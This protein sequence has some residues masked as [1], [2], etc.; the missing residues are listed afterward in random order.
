M[1]RTLLAVCGLSPQVITETLYA[2]LQDGRLP[3]SVHV[4]T[5]TEGKARCLSNLFGSGD[6]HFYKFLQDYELPEDAINFSP[7]PCILQNT[8]MK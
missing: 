5:T 4:L 1:K 7:R 8:N 2:L 3:D 6:G